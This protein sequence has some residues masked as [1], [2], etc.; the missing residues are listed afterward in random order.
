MQTL[1]QKLATIDLTRGRR[2]AQRVSYGVIALAAWLMLAAP[3]SVTQAGIGCDVYNAISPELDEGIVVAAVIAGILIIIASIA[4]FLVPDI[5]RL[6]GNWLIVIASVG[7]LLL[8][9]VNLP[10]LLTWIAQIGGGTLDVATVLA[11]C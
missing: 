7:L 2:L 9:Y 4:G 11:A 10:A 8:I 5:K 6:F 3:V 1:K